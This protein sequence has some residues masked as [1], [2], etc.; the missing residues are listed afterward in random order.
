MMM[1]H[2]PFLVDSLGKKITNSS[3]STQSANDSLYINQ[4]A[5][6]NGWIKSMAIA[7][8]KEFKRPRVIIIEGDHGYRDINSR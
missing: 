4:L 2:A 8:N 1:P 6:T 5:Y 3:S 7:A